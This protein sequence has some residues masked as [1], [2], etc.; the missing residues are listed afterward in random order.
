MPTRIRVLTAN[1]MA[2]GADPHAL[3]ALLKRESPDVAAFQELG[4]G[5]ARAL[6]ASGLFRSRRLDARADGNGL[7][8][9]AR[10]PAAF[11][12]LPLPGRDGWIA[13]L[14]HAETGSAVEIINVHLTPPHHL[15]PWAMLAARRRQIEMLRRHLG[16][17]APHPRI[18]VGDLNSTPVFPAYRALTVHLADAALL[19]AALDGGVTYPT[20][21]VRPGWRRLLRIDH[22]LVDPRLQVAGLR[23]ADLPGSDHA[24]LIVDLVLPDGPP[25]AQGGPA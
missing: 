5:Q 18:L 23:V 20:W 25:L 21:A 12:R 22:A 19:H 16:A 1:L 24:A 7:G 4:R 11:A 17:P 13:S 9:A 2:E 8:I 3:A 6:E 15:P 14:R 10:H